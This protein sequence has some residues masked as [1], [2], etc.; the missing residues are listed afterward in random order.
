[1]PYLHWETDRK[2]EAVARIIDERVEEF[3]QKREGEKQKE[4]QDRKD[5]RSGIIDHRP[6]PAVT[7]P[8][9]DLDSD[10]DVT[11]VYMQNFRKTS[12]GPLSFESAVEGLVWSRTR[13]QIRVSVDGSG[14]MKVDNELGQFLLDAARLY[15]A[16]TNHRDK[17]MIDNYLFNKAPLHPRRTLDQAH[18]WT[19]KSTRTRDRDQVVYRGTSI[20]PESMHRLKKINKKKSSSESSCGKDTKDPEWYWTCKE[21]RK[22]TDS[23]TS[24]T[25]SQDRRSLPSPN[26]SPGPSPGPGADG[27]GNATAE[28]VHGSTPAGSNHRSEGGGNNSTNTKEPPYVHSRCEHCLENIRKV[29]RVVMV[30]QLWMWVLDENTIITCFPRRYGV[31]KRDESGVHNSIRAR[32]KVARENQFRSVYDIALM[33][34][35][36]C[37]NTFFDRTKMSVRFYFMYPTISGGIWERR[38]A[39]NSAGA[40]STSYGYIL[41]SYRASG[42][43]LI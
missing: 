40:S 14:R 36:E 31:N 13:K 37:S 1:M 42:K 3:R 28:G 23:N 12:N 24:E 17:K 26:P 15:D 25:S 22:R 30:D 18:F 21:H 5:E 39:D 8:P 34:I 2:R 11:D 19:L 32:L 35:D 33:I 16:I 27:D 7:H 4:L 43:H 10:S 20:D 9:P 6:C 38:P 29:S 41:R